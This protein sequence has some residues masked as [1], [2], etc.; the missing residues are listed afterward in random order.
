MVG[1]AASPALAQQEPAT[2][3]APMTSAMPDSRAGATIAVNGLFTPE[4]PY[5]LM[6][7]MLLVGGF[8][9]SMFFTGVNA[10]AFADIADTDTGA[11][12]RIV[13]EA[14]ALAQFL[15]ASEET[16]TIRVE[17][18]WELP[19]LDKPEYFESYLA[20]DK[21]ANRAA[22]FAALESPITPPVIERQNEMQDTINNLLNAVANGEL[23]PQTALDTAKAELDKLIQ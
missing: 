1:L 15:T 19:A 23:D 6:L 18:G 4:T 22:V 8:I 9:R 12:D 3:A 13:A 11:M 20:L 21:P 16:A 10:L 2:P 5:P 14:A 7:T 17:T